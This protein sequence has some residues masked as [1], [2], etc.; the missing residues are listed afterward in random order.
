MY[1]WMGEWMT[2]MF[3][4]KVEVNIILKYSFYRFDPEI[5]VILL[6][7]PP[8]LAVYMLLWSMYSET[9]VQYYPILFQDC[10]FILE[11][12]ELLLKMFTYENCQICK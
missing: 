7:S 6:S 5:K 10:F 11:I 2:K 9:Y 8:S 1:E 3:V 4:N 12:Y